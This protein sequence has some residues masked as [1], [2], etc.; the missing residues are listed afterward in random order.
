MEKVGLAVVLYKKNY[1][2]VLQSYATQKVVFNLGF[3]PETIRIEGIE[4]EIKVAKVKYFIKR[5]LKLNEMKYLYSK[6]QSILKRKFSSDYASNST[7]RDKNYE[8]FIQ[9]WFHFSKLCN[10]KL[11]LSAMCK[12]YCAVIVGSDQ[13]WRPSNIEGDFFTLNFVTDEI[14]KIAYSTSFGV[15]VLPK[16]IV[17]KT[18]EF[19]NRFNYISVREESGRELVKKITGKDVPVL[20]DPSMLLDSDDWMEI[21]QIK[22]LISDKYILCYFLGDNS[23]HRSFARRLKMETGFKIIGLLHGATYIP[24]DDFFPDEALYDIGPSE[25][26]NLVRNAAYVC[27]D[28]F[29]G[30]VFSILYE[31][32]FFAFRRFKDGSESSTNDRLNTLFS[33]TG[34]QDRM[35]TGNE[36]VKECIVL[37]I[38]YDTVLA[39][40]SEKRKQ[41]IDF[42]KNA[43]GQNS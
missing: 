24:G 2:S 10:S 14:N 17:K 18:N 5:C 13:L 43:L 38:K 39:R 40:V 16:S 34:L 35:L 23:L 4:K 3:H 12:E 8:K 26:I 28:S 42:L 27:T 37:E 1:G 25:F 20:C 11:E 7:T 41:A 36:D 29:H 21:Q 9:K 30:S 6:I 15:S 31:R 19:L 33:W 22:P 32:T